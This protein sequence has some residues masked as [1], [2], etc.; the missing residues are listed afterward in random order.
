MYFFKTYEDMKSS[1]NS[2]GEKI[3]LLMCVFDKIFVIYLCIHE[4][5]SRN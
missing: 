3:M 2:D 4:N 5:G 1:I